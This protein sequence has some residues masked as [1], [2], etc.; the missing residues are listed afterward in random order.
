[1]PGSVS[2]FGTHFYQHHAAVV[3]PPG[4]F[5]RSI[6]LL[7]IA[8]F[9]WSKGRTK[10]NKD[11][12]PDQPKRVARRIS[13]RAKRMDAEIVEHLGK[14]AS[15]S[16]LRPRT[17]LRSAFFRSDERRFSGFV[18]DTAEIS[19]K[20]AVEILVMVIRSGLFVQMP[21]CMTS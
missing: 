7:P 19:R 20:Y 16:A 8:D 5:G 10:P 13:R 1:M 2:R 21:T 4:H 18:V 12:P 3:R 17:G 15:S 9:D 11:R 14:T 6:L